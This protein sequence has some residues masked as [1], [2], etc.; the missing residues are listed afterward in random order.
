[1]SDHADDSASGTVGSPAADLTMRI[2]ERQLRRILDAVPAF[3]SYVGPDLRYRFNNAAYAR[4][5]GESPAALRGRSVARLVGAET[6]AI[7]GPMLRRALAGEE[8]SF[9]DWLPADAAE[10]RYC[11]VQYIPDRL[12]DG[13][14]AGVLAL[15]NDITGRRR[16]EE[17]IERL[18]AENA[19]RLREMQVLFDAAPIGIFVGR[20]PS[21]RN[22]QMNRAGAEMLRIDPSVNP[23][24]S[25]PDAPAL[26]FRVFRDGRELQHDELPMQIAA[27]TGQRVDGFEEELVFDDGEIRNLITYAAPLCDDDG[28]V[29]GCVGTFADVTRSK[30]EERRHRETLAEADRRKDEFLSIL[31]HELRNPL[32]AMRSALDTLDE[33]RRGDPHSLDRLLEIIDRQTGH[34]QRLVDDLLDVARF[35]RGAMML[36]VEPVDLGAMVREAVASVEGLMRERRHRLQVELPPGPLMVRGDATRLVQVLV[37][38]LNNAARYTEPGGSIAVVL[39]RDDGQARISVEDNGSGIGADA[40]PH[41][42]ETFQQGGRDEHRAAGGLGLGLSLVRR[43][44]QMHGGRVAAS[45]DGPGRGS[46][47]VVT[48]PVVGPSEQVAPAQEDAAGPAPSGPSGPCAC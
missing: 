44:V 3:V 42:F 13:R 29:Y 11:Q 30:A 26:P 8:V 24:K 7:I 15:I 22:M 31:G 5:F 41:I 19:A 18:H 34:L 9:E 12:P 16:S 45:S 37:N 27:R 10:P 20:D 2:G 17:A 36:R 43:L 21:C 40:L 23:S 48:L 1:M 33:A 38:L 47:F 35:T 25:G 14:V 32:A 46:R 28:R 6:W 4:R 39:D